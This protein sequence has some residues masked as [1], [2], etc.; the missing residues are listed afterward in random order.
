MRTTRFLAAAALAGVMAAAASAATG[1]GGVING[2]YRPGNDNREA[3]LRLLLSGSQCRKGEVLLSW[4]AQGVPGPAG[5][6]GK[7]GAAGPQGPAGPSAPAYDFA[8]VGL[9]GT[10]DFAVPFGRLTASCSSSASSVAFANDTSGSVDLWFDRSGQGITFVKGLVSGFSQPASTV[11]VGPA[12]TVIEAH[13]GT[14]SATIEL[15][16]Y[17]RPG[18]SCEYSV[19]SWQS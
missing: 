4:N 15:W 11:P 19:A 5:A 3:S 7:D 17:H 8:T 16:Q 2:C 6:P 10:H 13:D 9:G 14:H 12:R 1:D 18:D